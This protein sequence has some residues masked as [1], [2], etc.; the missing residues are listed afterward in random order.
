MPL[1]EAS[2]QDKL[3]RDGERKTHSYEHRKESLFAM[4]DTDGSGTID[5]TEFDQL[6]E[7]I[8]NE[9]HEELQREE[10]LRVR[11]QKTKRRM[12][13]FIYAISFLSLFVAI[14]LAGNAA[15]VYMLL[16]VVKDTAASSTGE[17]TVKGDDA[18]VGTREATVDAP[19][20]TATAMPAE[21]LAGL[22]YITAKHNTKVPIANSSAFWLEPVVTTFF[23][24][25]ITQYNSTHVGFLTNA[26]Q[27][28]R[29]I[30]GMAYVEDPDTGD[31]TSLCVADTTCAALR[32]SA[33]DSAALIATAL[34][35][36][37]GIGMDQS[38]GYTHDGRPIEAVGGGG[39]RKLFGMKSF[40]VDVEASTMEDLLY[41]GSKDQPAPPPPPPPFGEPFTTETTYEYFG[42]ECNTV[43]QLAEAKLDSVWAV[44]QDTGRLRRLSPRALQG[45]EE[46]QCTGYAFFIDLTWECEPINKGESTYCRPVVG[47]M[48][49]DIFTNNDDG[50]GLPDPWE[51]DFFTALHQDPPYTARLNRDADD[52]VLLV[53]PSSIAAMMRNAGLSVLQANGGFMVC[54]PE[55]TSSDKESFLMGEGCACEVYP[56]LV[57]SDSEGDWVSYCDPDIEDCDCTQDAV[58]TY[59]CGAESGGFG[60]LRNRRLAA[61]PTTTHEMSPEGAHQDG[62]LLSRNSNANCRIAV[63]ASGSGYPPAGNS[64]GHPK[65][66]GCNQGSPHTQLCRPCCPARGGSGC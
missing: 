49:M 59:D 38:F 5:Q 58:M 51:T 35:A 13:V 32:V 21:D 46:V 24:T 18:I 6:Y 44:T 45:E 29:V 31:K 3:A 26:G 27:T 1:Q 62:R 4:V 47:S 48:G 30:N 34:A 39:R 7:V 8:K 16:D 19:L 61:G 40:Q 9:T 12:H 64:G 37:R 14:I 65:C 25:Q 43:V 52:Q 41:L 42:Q 54:T 28:L 53:V 66:S 36:L 33:D 10:L 55:E 23:V 22:R 15:L 17:L 63:C 60:L 56:P 11:L 57:W 50:S 20:F 2:L